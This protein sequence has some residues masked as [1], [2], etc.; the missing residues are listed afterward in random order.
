MA[1][2]LNNNNNNVD[3][4]AAPRPFIFMIENLPNH[5]QD[6][7][8][9]T[10]PVL[11]VHPQN[12][13]TVYGPVSK[14]T[15]HTIGPFIPPFARAL[16]V[17]KQLFSSPLFRN[18]KIGEVYF[19]FPVK[20]W[21][22]INLK[23]ADF[24]V[25]VTQEELQD[26]LPSM[27]DSTDHETWCLVPDMVQ[28]M[29]NFPPDTRV[30]GC[31][32][33]EEAMGLRALSEYISTS[34]SCNQTYAFVTRLCFGGELDEFIEEHVAVS[35]APWRPLIHEVCDK[36]CN[37]KV[38]RAHPVILIIEELPNLQED[39]IPGV[40]KE[41]FGSPLNSD[42]NIE[43]VYVKF[44][45][46]GWFKISPKAA[47]FW[48]TVTE[49][50]LQDMLPAM[51][52][53]NN[54]DDRWSRVGDIAQVMANFSGVAHIIGCLAGE[55]AIELRTLMDYIATDLN[56]KT[57]VFVT[58]LSTGGELDQF[59]EEHVA[60]ST[61]PWTPAVYEVCDQLFKR[62]ANRKRTSTDY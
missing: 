49:E 20:G 36:L 35:S 15:I 48:V 8:P 51:F 7:L 12:Y 22:K 52:S 24:W 4:S 17:L 28:V 5:Q 29:T 57:K 19:N 56:D 38:S 9:G 26:V 41:V 50:R 27:L 34:V 61:G 55:E 47:E 21:F 37:I 11:A 58:R 3:I 44:P 39:D 60:V 30:V 31:L 2:K 42:G 18:G 53:S 33:G 43:T 40:L 16:E 59:I 13:A 45:A 14:T 6:D 23:A 54:D 10:Y 25:N 46:E 62:M 32:A 1:E